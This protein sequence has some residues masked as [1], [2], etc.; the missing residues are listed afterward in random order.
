MSSR[1]LP[2]KN[3]VLEFLGSDSRPFHPRE[4]A[5]K[6]E[7]PQG[8]FQA[9]VN[10]LDDMVNVGQLAAKPGD[11][12]KLADRSDKRR[13]GN[14][15]RG[16][17]GG[18]GKDFRG[19]GHNRH[20][21]DRARGPAQG[22]EREGT[23]SVNQRGFGFVSSLGASGDDVFVPR[24]ALKGAMHGDKV[25]VQVR[26]RGPKGVEGDIVRIID[27]GMKR[28]A[29]VLRRRGKS[30]WLEPDDQRVRGPIPLANDIDTT[31]P[32]GN[33]GKDGDA[34]HRHDH[35]LPR[36]AGRDAGG[37]ARR[38]SRH[39]RRAERRGREDPR[40]WPGSKKVHSAE[41]FA[42]EPRRT[43]SRSPRTCSR[44]AKT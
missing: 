10:M 1:R 16:G 13:G 39:A 37:Q 5:E 41:A 35:A 36:A 25:V 34:G 23:L 20:G 19:G 28:V 6:L 26:A 18:G 31:G 7:V 8:S 24:E 17:G 30:A 14:D 2:P 42:E 44:G 22:E 21:G 3:E 9:L 32:E 29:G 40:R 12:Y 15:F 38:R 33:S 43:A 11:K 27:R 4:I